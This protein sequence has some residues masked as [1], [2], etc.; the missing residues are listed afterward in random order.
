[1]T[2]W[3]VLMNAIV[4]LTTTKEKRRLVEIVM[5][6]VMVTSAKI[7]VHI[8]WNVY[9]NLL[10]TKYCSPDDSNTMHVEVVHILQ[11]T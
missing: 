10:F 8:M 11:H 9:G 1:M 3:A 5:A 2:T 7:V 4:T 6:I